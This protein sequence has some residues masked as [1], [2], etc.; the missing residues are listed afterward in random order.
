MSYRVLVTDKLAEEGLELLRA[1]P[2]LEVVVNTKL[3]PKAL[4][5]ALKEADGIVIRSGTQLTAEVLQ[6]QTRLKV[7]VRAGVGVDNID[8]P[9]ATR[10]GIVV[11]NTPGGNTVSTA[12]HT[13]ALMLALSRNVAQAN[14]SLKAG[15]WDRNKFTGTQLGGK[16][17]GIVGLGRV[18]LAVAKRAQGFDMK[19]VGFDPFLS[20]ERAAELGI[21]SISP[22][23]DLWG[24]C[25]YITVHTPLSAETR[26]LIG[27]NELAKMKPNVRIIN[28]ARGGLI[29]EAALAEALTAGKIAGAAVDAFDPEP[30]PADN[31]LVTHP[32]VLVTPHLGAST[33]EAQVSVAVEAARLLSDFFQSG[34]IRF[35]VNM[36]TLDRAELD[37]MR[38][39]LDLGRRLGML[40]SQ[41]DRGTVK[42][43]TVRYRG[44]VASKNTRLITASFAA[45]WMESA[46]ED[47][48]N[49][50]NA[51]I[52]AKER[53]ITIV[54][55][56]TTDP[57]D[58][59]TLIQT[60]VVTEKK[61]YVAAGTLFGKEFVRLIRLGPYRLDA[62]LDGNL[63]VFTHKDV[64][65]LIGFIGT[66]FGRHNVNI[67]QMNVGREQPG[68]EAIGV[69]NLDSVPP[70]EAL[71]ELK[72]NPAI[73]SVSLIKLP[74]AGAIAPWLAQ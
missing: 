49:L 73:L 29:D 38:L 53:G 33:E 41:M 31:P 20:A 14:D 59:G 5:E 22:L 65:G 64:P 25:D 42:S 50:V 43:A 67:A 58:F 15:R 7:I 3:D 9:A 52:L 28:C 39:Y 61:Q 11:M 4:R 24:R 27:P 71:E 36:P 54:E 68:G 46:L 70:A 30:P 74:E 17:L 23:D 56:K 18:G 35:A 60:E 12:E 51:E 47:Q 55:E 69:V 16:T 8:V 44:E 66:T 57:G 63:L 13:M 32:Q 34:Q 19:V 6:D 72:K 62:H 21:E 45:G 40:H 1:E 48:V 26:N 37:E 10:Q 2:G